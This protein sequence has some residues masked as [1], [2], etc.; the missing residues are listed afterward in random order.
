MHRILHA[1][2]ATNEITD[3]FD[4]KTQQ[5]VAA[6]SAD[7]A[8]F[9]IGQ[10]REGQVVPG[11]KARMAGAVLRA[12]A[13]DFRAGLLQSRLQLAKRAGFTRAYRSEVRRRS[14]ER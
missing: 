3:A 14:E 12:D 5:S 11:A 7:H 8:L 6:I 9:R 13:D 4:A 2:V 10:Q 1:P